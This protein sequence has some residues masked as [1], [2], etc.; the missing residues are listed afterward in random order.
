WL[1][2]ATVLTPARIY[3]PPLDV[4][5]E[6]VR[7]A[8]GDSPIGASSYAHLGATMTRLGS[9]F[10]IAFV[11]GTLLGILGGRVKLAFDFMNNL[12]WIGMAVPSIVWVFIF[13]I[14]VG[15]S[16]AVP[17]AALIVLLAPPVLIAVAEGTKSISPEL[18]TMDD[19]YK[20]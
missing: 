10:A 12:V 5:E 8:S 15:I 17:I 16:D 1:L 9:A 14:A 19:S 13:V 18:I 2:T 6:L 7:L 4:W 20:V 3:P 11:L